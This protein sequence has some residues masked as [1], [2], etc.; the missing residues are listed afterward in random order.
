MRKCGLSSGVSASRGIRTTRRGSTYVPV[1]PRGKWSGQPEPVGD[2]RPRHIG[3]RSLTLA[4]ALSKR[5][6]FHP[7]VND[8][9]VV[10][11]RPCAACGRS[12]W[13]A[14]SV[15]AVRASLPPSRGAD[16]SHDGVLP[17]GVAIGVLPLQTV[18]PCATSAWGIWTAT[19]IYSRLSTV[20]FRVRVGS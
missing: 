16:Q 2:H 13:I 10:R 1:V 20:S 17:R 7:I 6:P 3:G 14:W 12:A 8:R 11:L 18:C 9:R 5:L 4:G 15:S 19:P